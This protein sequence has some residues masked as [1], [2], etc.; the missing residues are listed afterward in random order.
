MA[1]NDGNNLVNDVLLDDQLVELWPDY[2][3]LYDV[4]AAEFKN[5][6]LRQQA[7]EEIAKKLS[8]TG[9]YFSSKLWVYTKNVYLELLCIYISK[10]FNFPKLHVPES[11]SGVEKVN[12]P[13]W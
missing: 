10:I 6:D 8:Q 3:C 2:P 12:Y 4:R 13:D 7:M 11:M 5:R 9:A 1:T